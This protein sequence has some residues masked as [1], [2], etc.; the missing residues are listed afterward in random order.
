MT[1]KTQKYKSMFIIALTALITVVHYATIREHF[2]YHFLHRELFFVPILLTSFWFGLRYGL[3]AALGISILYAPHAFYHTGPHNPSWTVITQVVIFLLVAL[4]LG[5][6]SDRQRKEHANAVAAENLAVLGRAAGVVG[7]EMKYLLG[8]LK[9]LVKAA[10]SGCSPELTRGFEKETDRMERIVEVLTTFVAEER[11]NLLS[12]DINSIVRTAA[13]R[14]APGLEKQGIALDV[15]TDEAGC[16]TVVNPAHLERILHDLIQN[17][18][19]VSTPG[20]TIFIRSRRDEEN[21]LVEVRDEGPGIRPEHLPKIFTPFFT[22]KKNGHGLALAGARKIMRDMG[23][24]IEVASRLGEGAAFTLI[25]P[26][27]Y[28]G[29][30]QIEDPV[31]SI[32]QGKKEGRS[33][34]RE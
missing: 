25:I 31:S 7:D 5:W 20:K 33:M 19:D 6:L 30:P 12:S 15:D 21:C 28:S 14:R 9:K 1:P 2:G 29:K 3:L 26:R 27:D 8:S 24:E 22:T 4:L 32:I 17:A 13:D 11:E 34:Y 10:E 18:V 16:P 23:G